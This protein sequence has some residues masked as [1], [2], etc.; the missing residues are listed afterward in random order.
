L[1]LTNSVSSNSTHRG[2]EIHAQTTA[3]VTVGDQVIIPA[4]VFV[5]GKVDRLRRDGDRGEMLMQSVSVIFPDGY[6]ANIAGPI[7]ILSD[8]YTAWLTPGTGTKV[9][10]ILAPIAGVGIG[11][12]IGSAAHTTQSSTLGG[13]TLTTSTPKGI[14]IGS[15]V[16]LGVGALV[17][18]LVLT[19]SHQFFVDVGSPMQM[20]LPQPLTITQNDVAD[21]VR[22]AR[23]I[24]PA[25]PMPTP[26]Q[27]PRAFDHGTC[28]AAGA[29]GTSPALDPCP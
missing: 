25:F 4:G 21:N 16:G 20:T 14:A 7:N 17:S 23:D 29:P 24:P 27:W 1:V 2:D 8:E 22:E 26:R 6:V 13:T 9:A 5:Q 15:G 3:P 10:A 28:H 18:I 19:H 12:G 11:A